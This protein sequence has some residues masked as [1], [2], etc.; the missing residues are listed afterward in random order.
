MHRILNA[1]A[2]MHSQSPSETKLTDTPG[3]ARLDQC[4]A[5]CV[6][7]LEMQLDKL[8]VVAAKPK[9]VNPNIVQP[10]GVGPRV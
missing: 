5:E 8:L 2:N 3:G 4:V 1:T 6:A 7:K 10:G 9:P